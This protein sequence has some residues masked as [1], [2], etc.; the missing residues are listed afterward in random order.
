M[1][2]LKDKYGSVPEEL[3][4]LRRWVCYK[5][6]ERNGQKT[7]VPVNAISGSYAKSNDAATW[8]KFNIA[9]TGCEKYGCAGIGFMLGDG[10]F[11]IDLDNHPDKD[12]NITPKDE[13]DALANEFIQGLNSYSELSMSGLGIHII[14]AGKLPEGRRRKGN[15][16]MYD[17]GRFFAFTGNAINNVPIANREQEVIPLWKKYVDDS[18]EKKQYINNN[19]KNTYSFDRYDTDFR[20]RVYLTDGEVIKKIMNSNNATLFTKLYFDGDMSD[21]GDDHSSAD[22]GL[23]SILAFWCDRDSQQMDRIF[24]TSALMRPKWDEMRGRDTYG[25]IT[26]ENAIR[27]CANGYTPTVAVTPFIPKPKVESKPVVE[28]PKELEE[29]KIKA[30]MNID[31]NGDPI[32]RIKQIFKKYSLNDTGNAYRFY[33]NFGDLFKFNKTDKCFM[34][35]TGKTWIRDTKDIIKKYANKLIDLM[36]EEEASIAAEIK[37]LQEEGNVLEANNEDAYLKEFKKNRARIANK[38][39]K[40]AMLSELQSIYD[41]AVVSEEFDAPSC[42]YLLNTE[43][44]VVDLKTGELKPYEASYMISKNTNIT[45]S[46]EEPTVWLKFLNDIFDRPDKQE[47][48]EIIDCIQYCLGYSLSGS[49]DQQ[50]M[51][52]CY[53]DGSNGKSTFT[54]IIDY[55][56]GDYSTTTSSDLLMQQKN[57]GNQVAYSLARLKGAR[58]VQSSETEQG[59]RLAEARIKDITGGTPISAQFKYGNEFTYIPDFKLWM[60]T[61]NKPII[62]GEDYG[63]WRRI[64][65]FPFI[66]QFTEE[67]KDITLPK[68]L[69]QEAPKILGWCI[70]GFQK[71]IKEGKIPTPECIKQERVEYKKDMDVVSQ[72][73]YKNCIM[74]DNYYT[75]IKNF[76]D[77]YKFWAKDEGEFAMKSSKLEEGMKR[78][79]FKIKMKEGKPCYVGIKLNSDTGTAY[80]FDA[81]E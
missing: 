30:F 4:T 31:D 44:G 54:N 6:E 33:D 5:V 59:E 34:F 23:A 52:L 11:G 75:P 65:P 32:F 10:I 78:K 58:F 42:D 77:S 22:M 41:I 1:M 27:G 63:I 67:E 38:A 43:S 47:T 70:K 15:V 14:C 26:I 13:F 7:K 16:E 61:N 68:K 76:Y 21:Y 56:L 28:E 57:A 37:K 50:C 40:D 46:Y 79:G 81:F 29:G 19:Q 17:S 3:K 62:R 20:Q 39:G 48:A 60:C 2:E 55:I 49:I 8:T 12:G 18:E 71:Y 35:W 24:R 53:G 73:I 64:F 66:R 45:V 51:F 25:N 9:L 72:F 80:V 74:I 36:R 69:E